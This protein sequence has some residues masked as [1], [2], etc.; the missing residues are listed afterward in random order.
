MRVAVPVG[1]AITG[2]LCVAARFFLPNIFQPPN[3]QNP[4][5]SPSGLYS[6]HVFW[7]GG[8][9]AF[10]FVDGQDRLLTT[11][12]TD[13]DR[14]HSVYWR[15]DSSD[16]LWLYKSDDGL[17]YVWQN[18]NGRWQRSLYAEGPKVVMQLEGAPPADLL[19]EDELE[20]IR[21]YHPDVT[22]HKR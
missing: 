13:F 18:E 17:T 16:R 7:S 11:D 4:A 12:V 3:Q 1:L 6:V 19:P 10:D 9:W 8:D 2:F 20:H 22:P 14:H 15:W 5:L 21:K